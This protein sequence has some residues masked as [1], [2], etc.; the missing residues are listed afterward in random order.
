[1]EH[2][3]VC[4]VTGSVASREEHAFC[5]ASKADSRSPCPAL[6]A[7]ANHGYLPRDG[8]RISAKSVTDALEQGYHCT[9]PLAYV[10]AHGGFALL[11]QRGK[12]ICL[13]DL[14]RH[15][16]IEHNASLAH[17]DAG[18][19]DEYAPTHVHEE[20]LEEFLAHSK[21]GE[22]I[23]PDDVARA[24]V[25]RESVSGPVDGLHAEIARGE[26]AIAPAPAPLAGVRVDYLRTWIHQERFPDGWHPYHKVGLI[27]TMEMSG[28]IRSAMKR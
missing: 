18:H 21:D 7:L 23:T 13:S 16:R 1:H 20:L 26:M 2:T 22:I 12:T 27:H 15:N 24:R 3:D 9:K 5:P 11:G 4:P 8:K 17:P 6:N 14:A 19:R 28:K 10:L 25:R